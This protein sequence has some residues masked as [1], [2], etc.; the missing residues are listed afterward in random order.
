MEECNNEVSGSVVLDLLT[1]EE[2][3]KLYRR[4]KKISKRYKNVKEVANLKRQ[5]KSLRYIATEIGVSYTQVD[6][7]YKEYDECGTHYNYDDLLKRI[8]SRL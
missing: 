6:N 7:L 5:G 3:Y 8:K 2:L 4:V 1:K